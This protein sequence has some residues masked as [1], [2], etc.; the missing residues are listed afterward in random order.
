[1]FKKKKMLL[2]TTVLV[3][4]MLCGCQS[5]T[6]QEEKKSE[7]I[8]FKTKSTNT[9]IND[10][11][12]ITGKYNHENGDYYS[13]DLD[14]G[15]EKSKSNDTSVKFTREKKSYYLSTNPTSVSAFKTV[16][17]RSYDAVLPKIMKKEYKEKKDS[18]QELDKKDL[19]SF[20]N[21]C[22]SEKIKGA[23]VVFK[24]EK[25]DSLIAE[26]EDGSKYT[27]EYSYSNDIDGFEKKLDG[28]KERS[29]AII[30]KYKDVDF[31]KFNKNYDSMK[32]VTDQ[33]TFK[34][35]N[36]LTKKL[37]ATEQKDFKE[38]VQSQVEYFKLNFHT[39]YKDDT[40]FYHYWMH[41]KDVET[42]KKVL[43]AFGVDVS[44]GNRIEESDHVI[45]AED[46]ENSYSVVFGTDDAVHLL[47]ENSSMK[48]KM[49]IIFYN[50]SNNKTK[51][52]FMNSGDFFY[53][54]K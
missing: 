44:R 37:A 7:I 25:F 21:V 43:A 8:E 42:A 53:R 2:A 28:Y 54:G 23:K 20:A 30:D 22:I 52:Y 34:N 38:F 5:V 4:G 35:Y 46:S 27:E 17:E 3:V 39:Y 40:V 11:F 24:N 18:T 14:S 49:E 33:K 32:I 13:M 41:E 51:T 19:K 50:E 47:V 12:S 9:W 45:I 16:D 6:Q 48:N 15:K 10:S 36:G 26:C 1:M 29:G 31:K